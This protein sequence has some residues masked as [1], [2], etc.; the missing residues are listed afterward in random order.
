MKKVSVIIPCYNYGKYL[1][2]C[3]ESVINQ[4]RNFLE[5]ETEIIVVNDGST[6]DTEEIVLNLGNPIKYIRQENRGLS[7][8]R[9]AGLKFATGDYVIFLDADDLLLPNCISSQLRALEQSGK[10]IVV[11]QHLPMLSFDPEGPLFYVENRLPLVSGV[12][13]I[14]LCHSNIAPVH[15]YM[16]KSGVVKRVGGFDESLKACEDYDFWL[17]C[18]LYDARIHLNYDVCVIYRKHHHSMSRNR[19]NQCFYD[20]IVHKRLFNW[21]PYIKP[22][23]EEISLAFL[24]YAAGC[25]VIAS[26]FLL[27][28]QVLRDLTRLATSALSLATNNFYTKYNNIFQY[29]LAKIYLCITYLKRSEPRLIKPIE[30]LLENYCRNINMKEALE[31]KEKVYH[32]EHTI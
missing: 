13:E 21:L 6:D 3:I 22:I 23:S 10:D 26:Q 17:R 18:L 14:H 2:K 27:K 5:F 32:L 20:Y 4:E 25:L 16:V 15:A 28:R 8:A 19:Y 11:C 30:K 29:Y 1:R 7:S 24:C 31:Q 9:N 12:P